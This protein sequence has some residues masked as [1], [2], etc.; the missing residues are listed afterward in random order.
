MSI[1]T[2]QYFFHNFVVSHH[3]IIYETESLENQAALLDIC[4]EILSL[5]DLAQAAILGN[6][7][8]L[9]NE[10]GMSVLTVGIVIDDMVADLLDLYENNHNEV[11]EARASCYG[12]IHTVLLL[13]VSLM[14]LRAA[15]AA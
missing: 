5:A 14:S 15:A 12:K 7:K 2:L 3:Y 9:P 13:Q 8:D 10:S 11:F 1:L 4:L 6:Q